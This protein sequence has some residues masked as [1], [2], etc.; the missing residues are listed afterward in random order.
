LNL[1]KGFLSLISALFQWVWQLD[2]RTKM[3]GKSPQ[4][5]RIRGH[6]GWG[7]SKKRCRE[8]ERKHR[9]GEESRLEKV[10][11]C[12]TWRELVVEEAEG[13]GWLRERQTLSLLPPPSQ[14]HTWFLFSSS[15]SACW[16]PLK[17][18]KSLSWIIIGNSLSIRAT[19]IL[20]L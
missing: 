12:Y 18:L 16:A 14:P 4:Q 3:G 11:G 20:S 17:G 2:D 19:D 6:R 1:Y 9:E 10:E 8:R 5:N 15:L 7:G 13:G